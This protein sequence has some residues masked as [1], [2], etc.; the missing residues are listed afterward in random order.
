MV[1]LSRI[2]LVCFA[3][4]YSI[5][6][7]LEVTRIFFRSGVRQAV[8]IGFA[9]AGLVAHSLFLINRG[10]SASGTPLSSSFDWY[11]LA[12]WVLANVYLYLTLYHPRIPL[13][14]F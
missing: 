2:T 11:L 7:A 4:S 14:L 1:I 8:M 9:A 5:A 6:L 12:A 13:G 3:A 10:L